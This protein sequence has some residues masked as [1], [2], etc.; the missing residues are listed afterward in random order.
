MYQSTA[1]ALNPFPDGYKFPKIWTQVGLFLAQPIHIAN[2]N[3]YILV[4]PH[5]V[6]PGKLSVSRTFGDVEA[7]VPDLGG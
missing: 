3:E 7:K 6:L 1:A 5:R 4:G 2:P